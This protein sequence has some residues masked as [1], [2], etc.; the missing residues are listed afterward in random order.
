MYSYRFNKNNISI[1][2]EKDK[3][4]S[5]DIFIKRGNFIINHSENEIINNYDNLVKLSKLFINQKIL[6]MK[7]NKNLFA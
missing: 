7:Y 1:V 4:E 3:Y 6:K 2:L 5:I